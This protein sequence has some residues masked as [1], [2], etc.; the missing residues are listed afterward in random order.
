MSNP[1]FWGNFDNIFD[2]AAYYYGQDGSTF[3]HSISENAQS[4][5]KKLTNKDYF[6]V[7]ERS[8]NVGVTYNQ[9]GKILGFF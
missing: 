1:T 2:A 7:L 8:P 3:W 4:A 6:N 9:N 5:G